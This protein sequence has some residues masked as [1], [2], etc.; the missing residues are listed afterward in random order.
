MNV[1]QHPYFDFLISKSSHPFLQGI[2]PMSEKLLEF[3]ALQNFKGNNLTMMQVLR[4][5]NNLFLSEKTLAKRIKLLQKM[6]FIEVHI[7]S[8]DRRVK[9]LFPTTKTTKYFSELSKHI[10]NVNTAY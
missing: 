9:F 5:S 3:I 1:S 10:I 8:S 7:D 4:N 6:N 2:D